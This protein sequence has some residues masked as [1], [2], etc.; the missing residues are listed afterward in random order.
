MIPDEPKKGFKGLL[1]KM[2]HK[3]EPPDAAFPEP[4]RFKSLPPL[5]FPDRPRASYDPVGRQR[6]TPSPRM[7]QSMYAEESFDAW[8]RREKGKKGLK[9]FFGGAKAGRVA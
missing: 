4:N 3:K 9:S 7:V 8:P 6:E 5:P 1:Q 2:R